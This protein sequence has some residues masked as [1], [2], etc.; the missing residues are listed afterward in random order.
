MAITIS[1]TEGPNVKGLG[2]GRIPFYVG[3][4][5][6]DNEPVFLE[7]YL[8]WIVIEGRRI[9]T[10]KSYRL[11][12]GLGE[13]TEGEITKFEY[14]ATETIFYFKIRDSEGRLNIPNQ[15]SN[16]EGR[17]HY[18]SIDEAVST[19]FNLFGTGYNDMRPNGFEDYYR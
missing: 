14:T 16:L 8:R 15:D 11:H 9:G 19:V 4:L 10:P 7:S 3:N 6:L 1:L 18:G 13:L 2:E 5:D 12:M 17:I